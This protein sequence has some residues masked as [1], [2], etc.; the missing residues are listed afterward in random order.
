MWLMVIVLDS[1]AWFQRNKHLRLNPI[2]GFKEIP[3]DSVISQTDFWTL[4]SL[5]GLK[6]SICCRHL[7]FPG[8]KLIAMSDEGLPHSNEMDCDIQKHSHSS[9]WPMRFPEYG[10]T[11]SW[12]SPLPD[13]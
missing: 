11:Q 8:V 2:R 4:I 13:S 12:C 6:S 7:L 5:Y 1:I 9:P 3:D 10:L